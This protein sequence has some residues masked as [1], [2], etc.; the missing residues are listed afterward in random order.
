MRQEKCQEEPQEIK[1]GQKAQEGQREGHA[2]DA[3]GTGGPESAVRA[4]GTRG[5]NGNKEEEKE[6]Q[7]QKWRED[8][9]E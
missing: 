2:I 6:G 1:E 4:A 7:G 3:S 5:R 8:T 9:P